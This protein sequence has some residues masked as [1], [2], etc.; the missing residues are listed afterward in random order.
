M[1]SFRSFLMIGAVAAVSACQPVVPDSGSGVVDPGRGVGFDNPNTLAAR[2][3]RDTQLAAAAV[4]A[5]PSVGTQSL[6]PAS[7]AQPAVPATTAQG[8]ATPRAVSNPASLDAELAQIAAEN[9]AAAAR[10]NSGQAVLNASPSNAAPVI[11]NNPGISDENNFDAVSS[12][13]SI[14]SDA[15]RLE[16]NRQ[17]YQVVQ[18]TALPSRTGNAQPNVVQ[19]ALQTR[20]PK[21]TRVHRR[22]GV[23]SAAK[24]QRNCAEYSSADEAQIDFLA[25]GGPERDRRGIDPDG[26][27]YACGWD[28]A[29]FRRAAGN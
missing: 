22:F 27:G 19:Y 4:P 28:P 14:E 25:R 1:L 11:L 3:A 24:F 10:G 7:Q 21:G 8:R 9:D 15:A 2:E 23:G 6:P 29:P 26:D 13:Q 5:A 16:A 17:Q 12:R 18:P 20:H